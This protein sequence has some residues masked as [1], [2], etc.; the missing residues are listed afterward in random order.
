[1]Q[2]QILRSAVVLV[3]NRTFP[4]IHPPYLQI[5]KTVMVYISLDRQFKMLFVDRVSLRQT[6]KID[7]KAQNV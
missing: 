5:E 2:A 6:R 3:S 7:F 4:L 1:M